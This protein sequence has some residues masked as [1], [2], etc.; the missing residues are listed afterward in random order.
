MGKT[1]VTVNTQ[2]DCFLCSDAHL[3]SCLWLV[4]PIRGQTLKPDKASVYRRVQFASCE[5]LCV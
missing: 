2:P 1:V 5:T 3:V 4:L